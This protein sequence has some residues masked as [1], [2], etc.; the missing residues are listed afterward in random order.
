M[1]R[2]S[3]SSAAQFA[4][5]PRSVVKPAMGSGRAVKHASM[6]TVELVVAYDN[7]TRDKNRLGYPRLKADLREALDKFN[8]DLVLLSECGEVGKGRDGEHRVPMLLGICG[9]E[10]AIYVDGHCTTIV[11]RQTVE[12]TEEPSLRGPLPHWKRHTCRM[13][14]HMQVTVKGN[15]GKPINVFN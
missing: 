14:Q 6:P 7:L 4:T 13:C 1:P 10:Y 2:R 15:T 12:F 3:S 8:T 11:N 9:E 5:E